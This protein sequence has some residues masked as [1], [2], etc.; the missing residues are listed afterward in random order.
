MKVK[1]S[2]REICEDVGVSHVQVVEVLRRVGTK[3]IEDDV[4]VIT[5]TVGTFY[6]RRTIPTTK[7]L[8]GTTYQVPARETVALRGPKFPGR[9]IVVGYTIGDSF[10]TFTDGTQE[11][12]EDGNFTRTIELDNGSIITFEFFNHPP[13][14]TYDLQEFDDI[15]I[16]FWSMSLNIPSGHVGAFAQVWVNNAIPPGLTIDSVSGEYETRLGGNLL[17]SVETRVRPESQQS[18][19]GVPSQ[20]TFDVSRELDFFD[21]TN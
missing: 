19:N 12:F 16:G 13:N 14:G 11:T 21:N 10:L 8:N 1:Q 18:G 6:K 17:F 20:I 4:E 9:E 5:Q 15:E 2:L 3:V 7:V